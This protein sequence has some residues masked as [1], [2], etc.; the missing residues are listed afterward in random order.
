MNKSNKRQLL[1][2]SGYFEHSKFSQD[3]EL[4]L[5]REE[6]EKTNANI[7]VLNTICC[8]MLNVYNKDRNNEKRR[9]KNKSIR[10]EG[11]EYRV[12]VIFMG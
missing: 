5:I 4:F 9:I 2:E 6:W 11:Y 10:R 8:K 7:Q 1:E 3:V 12:R